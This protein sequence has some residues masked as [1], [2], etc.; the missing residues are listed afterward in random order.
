MVIARGLL[1]EAGNIAKLEFWRDH[2]TRWRESG[3]S[4]ADYCRQ[5][6][7]KP[8]RFTYWKKRVA[9][10]SHSPGAKVLGARSSGTPVTLVRLP[11]GVEEAKQTAKVSASR[12]AP[13]KTALELRVGNDYRIII[14]NDFDA[15]VLKNLIQTLKEL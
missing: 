8:S 3:L 15:G 2:I 12:Q 10:N 5:R 9:G 11:V 13:A 1:G 6:G 14:Q 7:L 4:Q